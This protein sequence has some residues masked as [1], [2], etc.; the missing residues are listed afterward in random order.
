M[1]NYKNIQHLLRSDW[2]ITL[3][4]YIAAASLKPSLEWPG[5]MLREVVRDEGVPMW[6]GDGME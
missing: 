5:E 2:S 3:R 6:W 4:Q 1:H